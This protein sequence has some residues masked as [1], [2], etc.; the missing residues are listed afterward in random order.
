MPARE[1]TFT[2]KNIINAWKACGIIPFNPRQVLSA[3]SRNHDGAST[4]RLSVSATTKT[5]STPRAVSRTTRTAISLVTRSTPSSEKLKALLSGLS[6]GFQ[7]AIADKALAEEAHRQYRN[8]VAGDK[9][10]KTSDRR[11]LTEATVVTTE[12]VLELREKR[13]ALDAAKAS[14]KAKQLSKILDSLSGSTEATV[15]EG[16]K[17]GKGKGKEKKKEEDGEERSLEQVK[18]GKKKAVRIAKVVA[19][20]TIPGDG[21]DGDIWEED[22]GGEDDVEN[23]DLVGS[24]DGDGFQDPGEASDTVWEGSGT[25]DIPCEISERVLRPRK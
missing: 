23:L 21:E 16:K 4:S 14:K 11:K 5:P 7:Q 6:E 8:L 10:I 3:E 9:K 13:E 12:L 17:G 20:H 2:P 18:G 25:V 24:D 1:S 19:V 15:K 22:I